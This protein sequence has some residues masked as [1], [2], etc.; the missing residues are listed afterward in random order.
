MACNWVKN[1]QQAGVRE[2]LI[3][4]L[5]QGMM[6]ACAKQGVPC[7]LVDG[8]AV[9]A[10]LATRRAQNVRED[11][12]L[13]PK[14]SVLKVGFYRELLSFGFNVWACDADAIFMNDPRPLMRQGAWAH[15]DVAIATDCIDLPSDARYP[16]L[17][18]DFNTGLVYLRSS[19]TTL[20]F[21]ERWKETVASAR[22]KRIRDQAAFNMITKQPGRP[23]QHY[24][25]PA[26][27]KWAERLFLASNGGDAMLKLL[28]LP[29]N[30]FLNG[31]T[32][33]VQ[34]A[35]TL[36]GAQPPIS[37]HMTYQFGEGAKYAYGKRQR[38]REAGLWL[39]DDDAYYSGKF[40]MVSAAA[41]N[42]P[43]RRFNESVDSREAV[44][45]HLAE[46]RH[47]AAVLRALLGVGKAT[48]RAVILPRMLCY[49][50]FMWKEMKAC[51]VG[52]AES[53][54]LPFDCPMDHALDTPVWFEHSLGV[55]VREP[56]FLDNA[57]VS[58]QLKASRA[59]VALPRGL[60]DAG[61]VAALAPHADA[62]I[63]EIEDA[64]DRFCGF[65]DASTHATF[66]DETQRMLHYRRAHF[67]TMEG[68]DNAPLFSQCCSPRKPGD[69]FFP[70]KE[71]FDPPQPLPT[72][73]AS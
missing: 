28:V 43:V 26:T 65:A 1:V 12:T 38:L 52:G 5:D 55:S 16:L 34:H 9:T 60:N 54:R 64:V 56:N 71:G 14:M 6:D 36:P 68:S 58:Q 63:I 51:R 42:L 18:C 8:G 11:P 41:A 57:R 61:V 4:A 17:H 15:A 30:R 2:V 67:C 35:H 33:F 19:N 69:K 13:Y 21:A 20:A 53:M 24:N 72:C 45:Y 59:T 3:G 50:D 62:A 27:G 23:L 10:A 70:C 37:V 66:R 32:F 40:V 7:V 31:H 48:G 39:V 47:R 29:L 44:D 22:E 46:G 25:D 73:A 49:C